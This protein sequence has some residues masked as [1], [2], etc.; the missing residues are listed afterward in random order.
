MPKRYEVLTGL[1]YPIGEANINKAKAG[2][3][4]EVTKWKRAE[5]GEVVDDI[6]AVSV[7]WLLRKGHIEAVAP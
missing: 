3:L 1:T 5:P 6:P 7:P 2:K 4:D